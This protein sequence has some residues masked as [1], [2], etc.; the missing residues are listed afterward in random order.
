MSVWLRGNV[1]ALGDD[2]FHGRAE[3]LALGDDLLVQPLDRL[4]TTPPLPQLGFAEGARHGLGRVTPDGFLEGDVVQVTAGGTSVII[5]QSPKN[6]G[7]PLRVEN[8]FEDDVEASVE[9]KASRHVD[10]SRRM[11]VAVI[12]G[13]EHVPA[14]QVLTDNRHGAIGA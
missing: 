10:E 1:P 8:A 5:N 9:R 11:A 4:G 6:L 3:G 2:A 14:H 13:A 7:V 12:A